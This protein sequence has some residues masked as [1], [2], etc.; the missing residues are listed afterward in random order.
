M[1]RQQTRRITGTQA[2]LSNITACLQLSD[3]LEP[4]FGSAGRDIMLVDE[5]G[6]VML[7]NSGASLLDAL[8]IQHPAAVLLSRIATSQH[9]GFGDGTTSVVLLAS[10]ILR[11]AHTLLR[12]G[13]HAAVLLH[14][15]RRLLPI[16]QKAIRSISVAASDSNDTMFRIARTA[17]SARVSTTDRE[18]LANISVQ[19]ARLSSYAGDNPLYSVVSSGRVCQTRIIPGIMFPLRPDTFPVHAPLSIVSPRIIVTRI[20]LDRPRSRIHSTTVRVSS[21]IEGA[22]L[23]DRERSILME[24]CHAIIEKYHPNIILNHGNVSPVVAQYFA[25]RGVLCI[26]G[27][28]FSLQSIISAACGADIVTNT[29]TGSEYISDYQRQDQHQDQPKYQ[30]FGCGKA[31]TA[32]IVRCGDNTYLRI[33]PCPYPR[34]CT[35]WVRGPTPT[36][37]ERCLRAIKD[38]VV[39]QSVIFDG[40]KT[41][42]GNSGRGSSSPSKRVVEGGGH[43]YHVAAQALRE[44]DEGKTNDLET[45]N[46]S[47]VEVREMLASA[48]ERLPAILCSNAGETLM[49]HAEKK[50]NQPLEPEDTIQGVLRGAVEA[51]ET[52]LRIDDNLFVQ[53]RPDPR[54]EG[55]I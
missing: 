7:D 18:H 52:I 6:D 37:R 35:V 34:A 55:Y 42:V 1:S 43:S 30:S 9:Q 40:N 2:S 11:R 54:E 5:V 33:A 46:I 38:A 31:G 41:S 27:I 19:A 44:S 14:S 25:D 39:A 24:R 36:V 12:D 53:P 8:D 28:S 26:G 32:A 51:A 23:S 17:L 48:L 10:E 4:T 16:A 50:N 13:M 29:R 21:H 15:I 47:H 20:D 3:A 22:R 45:R 49:T